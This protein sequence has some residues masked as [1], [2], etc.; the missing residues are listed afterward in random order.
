MKNK[1]ELRWLLLMIIP[2]MV[3]LGIH[4]VTPITIL[5]GIQPFAAIQYILR[6]LAQSELQVRS[7]NMIAGLAVQGI[8]EKYLKVLSIFDGFGSP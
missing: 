3:M 4:M 8:T 7:A 2:F 6:Q 1:K 5:A